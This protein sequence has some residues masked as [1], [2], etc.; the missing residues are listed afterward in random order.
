MSCCPTTVIA[1]WKSLAGG[2]HRLD[3]VFVFFNVSHIRFVVVPPPETNL[4]CHAPFTPIWGRLP[5][6]QTSPLTPPCPPKGKEETLRRS[7][8]RKCN[9]CHH[10][11]HAY[12]SCNQKHFIYGHC[13]EV[14]ASE[15]SAATYQEGWPGFQSWWQQQDTLNRDGLMVWPRWSRAD[16]GNARSL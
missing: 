11:W 1:L 12:W 15:P 16:K 2:V 14:L 7:A 5:S 10:H 4:K 9:G 13:V 6:D 8:E 3:I